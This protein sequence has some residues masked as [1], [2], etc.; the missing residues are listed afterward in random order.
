[1][2]I[3]IKLYNKI[4]KYYFPIIIMGRISYVVHNTECIE[5]RL[6]S[7]FIFRV[8]S[9]QETFLCIMYMWCCEEQRYSVI[10]VRWWI[11]SA[12]N[13]EQSIT[14]NQWHIRRMQMW[15]INLKYSSVHVC[16]CV[17]DPNI[18]QPILKKWNKENQKMNAFFRGIRLKDCFKFKFL[19][20]VFLLLLFMVDDN[21]DSRWDISNS[22]FVGSSVERYLHFIV[23]VVHIII[24]VIHIYL[25]A[26]KQKT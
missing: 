23:D 25:N 11:T 17:K 22:F 2:V 8:S 13:S 1:M 5:N 3:T 9:T 21:F 15:S 18:I 7:S 20:F 12:V 6:V 4:K 14:Y 26:V 10:D 16:L 19:C 24:A